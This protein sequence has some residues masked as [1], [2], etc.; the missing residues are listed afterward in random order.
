MDFDVR[1]RPEIDES[2]RVVMSA[3][4][5]YARS[6]AYCGFMIDE[7]LIRTWYQAVRRSLEERARR[8]HAA[9]EALTAGHGGEAAT[10][11][12]T[13]VARS[14][15][16]ARGREWINRGYKWV[17]VGHQMEEVYMFVRLNGEP[18]VC[19]RLS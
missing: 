6:A 7:K 13:K 11:R 14:T 19:A 16:G 9:A 10:S 2:G 18:P 4:I 8:L 3:G 1:R 12:A 15:M 5:P 17:K